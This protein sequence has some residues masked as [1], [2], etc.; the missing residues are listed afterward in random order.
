LTRYLLNEFSTAGL[1]LLVVG[2]STLVAL[3]A[4]LAIRKVFP[5]L[6][7]SEAKFEEVT[8]VLRA[9]VFALLYTIV[10]A[11]VIADVSG[12]FTEASETV[13]A[14]ASAVAQLARSAS[15]FSADARDVINDSAR[16]YVHAV[17]EDEWPS[18]RTGQQSP[19]AAAA[20]EGLYVAYKSVNPQTVTEEAFYDSSVGALGEVTLQRRERLLQSQE[21]L[22]ALLRVLLVVGGIVFVIL[23]FPASV[24]SLAGQLLI[25]G[26]TA[27]F[28]SFAYLL[29]IVLDYPYAG[30]VAV[31]TAPFKQGALARYWAY[32]GPPQQ[33]D[34][35]RVERLSPEDLIGVWNSDSSFGV[36]C[37]PSGG[38]GDPRRLP[39]RRR[40][41][42][43][44]YRRRRCT[45]RMVVPGSDS[46]AT[47]R[48]R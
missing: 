5:N 23:G 39:E 34:P 21:G 45:P 20:L 25:V 24:R 31:D 32:E 44:P 35:E 43:R 2:G 27:A 11:L 30:Q 29:T 15:V 46:H 33:L 26:A 19:R 4:T 37:F 48:R 9:D 3:V 13:L 40:H 38:R 6:P 47:G 17:V 22:S 28:V 1:V 42:R 16:E 18:M 41:G 36:I 8:G 14:E 12:N 10:L 7:E